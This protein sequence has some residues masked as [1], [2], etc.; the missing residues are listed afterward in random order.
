MKHKAQ[1][2]GG[3]ICLVLHG[4]SQRLTQFLS[5]SSYSHV[6]VCFR[7]PL[8]HCQHCDLKYILNFYRYKSNYRNLHWKFR[9]NIKK[10]DDLKNYIIFHCPKIISVDVCYS[11]SSPMVFYCSNLCLMI[12]KVEHFFK[13]LKIFILFIYF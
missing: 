9:K 8:K 3:F 7:N 6:R 1:E 10:K 11:S 13:F 5:C 4:L 12:S 2:A